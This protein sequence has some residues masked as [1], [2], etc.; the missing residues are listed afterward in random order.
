MDHFENNIGR[1]QFLKLAGIGLAGATISACDSITFASG[2][3]E[4]HTPT[5]FN[6]DATQTPRPTHKTPTPSLSPTATFSPGQLPYLLTTEEIDF[7]AE[8]EVLEGDTGRQVV[9]LTYD[10]NAKYDDV[11]TILDA[12]KKHDAK[13]TFFF[14]GEKIAGSSKA[15]RAIIDEGHSL[16]CHSWEHINLLKLN[17]DQIN[18]QI[19]RCF[20]AVQ[21]VV[22]GYRMR[23]IRFPFGEGTS[24][25]R[26][27]GISAAWGLQHVGWSMGSGGLDD[28]TYNNV[29]RNVRNGSIVLS[30][31]F[32]PYDVSQADRIVGS[33]VDLGYSLEA[34]DTGRKP[35]DIYNYKEVELWRNG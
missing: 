7:L 35:E 19:E 12:L 33:L 13:A 6:A 26:L 5:A 4:Q 31:M 10:D 27:L 14:I 21:E 20:D 1:R 30:H 22:P 16:G 2:A 17:D 25:A 32:R 11:R 8:H 24:D 28:Q 18:R 9:M 15:V 34:L 23:F 29:M 3:I